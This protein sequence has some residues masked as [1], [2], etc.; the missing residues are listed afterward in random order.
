MLDEGHRLRNSETSEAAA[1]KHLAERSA[2]RVVLS[3][4][5]YTNS[6]SDLV[7]VM[8]LLN[9]P[10]LSSAE[11]REWWATQTKTLQA[12]DESKHKYRVLM[13]PS[14]AT[15][16]WFNN[17]PL[18]T[19]QPNAVTPD[20]VLTDPTTYNF[21]E[22]P[23]ARQLRR[24]YENVEGFLIGSI[25]NQFGPSMFRRSEE[26]KAFLPESFDDLGYPHRDADLLKTTGI[27]SQFDLE[28]HVYHV[29]PNAEEKERI[30]SC[31]DQYLQ[32]KR[33]QKA[34]KK[35]VKIAVNHPADSS[36]A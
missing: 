15:N 4:T 21:E 35:K 31:L 19:E 27:L 14:L 7:N 30:T 34:S 5:T 28:T 23:S 24:E 26:S 3:A 20:F 8:T 32:S 12:I 22:S 6:A 11:G 1:V 36:D 10:M 2:V 33:S 16:E 25:L 29:V 9:H 13:A 18:Q 17:T